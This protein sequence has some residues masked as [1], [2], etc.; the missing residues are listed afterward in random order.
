MMGRAKRTSEAVVLLVLAVLLASQETYA[1]DQGSSSAAPATA[2]ASDDAPPPIIRSPV[3]R[4]TSLAYP[5]WGSGTHTLLLELLVLA[6]GTVKEARVVSGDL[7]FGKVATDA[8]LTWEFAPATKG[9]EPVPA[10]IRF[11]VKFEPPEEQEAPSEEE[12]PPQVETKVQDQSVE[13]TTATG[14]IEVTVHGE[15]Q[16]PEGARSLSRAS[17]RQLP[18]AFG[19]AFRA[20][21]SLP[22][23]TP[24]VSGL[25]YFYVRGAPPGNIG[26]F[27]DGIRVPL[28]YHIAAGPSVI[29]PAF[30]EQVDLYAGPYP[31]RYGRFSGGVIAG[32]TAP[33]TYDTRG[34]VSIRLVDSGAM[35]ETHAFDHR[36]SVM[37]AG[38]YSYT[39]LILS[40][41]APEVQLSYWDYQARVSYQLNDKESISVFGFGALDRAFDVP[42]DG[43]KESVFDLIFHRYDLRY[44]RRFDDG[45]KM[46]VALLGGTE[47][48]G[49]GDFVLGD[50]LLGGRIEFENPLAKNLLLRSGVDLQTDRYTARLDGDVFTD[51]DE[52]A[53]DPMEADGPERGG[54][55]ED[56]ELES[57]DIFPARVDVVTGARADLV[58]EVERGIRVV[59]GMRFDFFVTNGTPLWSISPRLYA[60]FDV[61]RHF[62]IKHGL[63]VAHQL[64]SFIVPLP[65]FQPV[66]TL[67]L[68]RALQH[69]AGVEWRLPQDYVAEAT[70]FQNIQLNVTDTLSAIRFDD[71]G[72]DL[73][74][75]GLGSARGFEFMVRRP[76]TKR[77]GGY[78]SYTY[79]RSMRSFGRQRGPSS[80]DRTH[81]LSSALGYQMGRGWTAGVRGSFYTGVPANPIGPAFDFQHPPRTRP[82]YRFDWRLEKRWKVGD[83]GAW[84]ALVF[85]VLNTTLNKEQLDRNCTFDPCED[86]EPFGPLTIPSIGAE[87]SF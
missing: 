39:A 68:Q 58:W 49:A 20:V 62:T 71:V 35:I 9:G 22:G 6:D 8:A 51:G 27:L 12:A 76:L 31:A 24:I 5:D 1:Q 19:D 2:S 36:L 81:V 83:R 29:H 17:V 42:E 74:A 33:P 65:G 34:E 59:P 38:R 78:L 75:R 70:V 84:W 69:S 11:E 67:G 54:E 50:R 52:E 61:Y 46:R 30:I 80:F 4:R 26:Y 18:G 3:A 60:E 55:S 64:P 79:S 43:P 53:S 77:L 47:R 37:A 82:F 15:R 66:G 72:D 13:E 28:L 85:E 7:R 40:L 32:E 86:G 23:V 10:W 44:D 73:D 16:Q 56:E 21:E 41:L 57:S 63:G 14:E 25:P 87:A 45:G 48:T